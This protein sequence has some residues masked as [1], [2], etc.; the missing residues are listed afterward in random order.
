MQIF[1]SYKYLCRKATEPVLQDKA[2]KL[3]TLFGPD[4]G[5][6]KRTSNSKQNFLKI[7]QEYFGYSQGFWDFEVREYRC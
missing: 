3:C 4:T 1:F 6:D 2:R 7:I 5:L